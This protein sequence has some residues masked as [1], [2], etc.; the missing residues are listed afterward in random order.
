MRFA[1]TLSPWSAWKRSMNA[2]FSTW[3][4]TWWRRRFSSA[5]RSSGGCCD[6]LRG[7][8][9]SLTQLPVEADALVVL[10]RDATLLRL[11]VVG[12]DARNDGVAFER[13][14]RWALSNA[15]LCRERVDLLPSTRLCWGY[16]WVTRDALTD[17]SGAVRHDR[18]LQATTTRQRAGD[19]GHRRPVDPAR[20]LGSVAVSNVV[21]F[22]ARSLSQS[23][24]ERLPLGGCSAA[25]PGAAGAG[26]ALGNAPGAPKPATGFSGPCSGGLGSGFRGFKAPPRPGGGSATIA[27]GGTK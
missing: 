2:L 21:V 4:A 17:L 14:G 12:D 10:A 13:A 22:H 25:Q 15:A 1:L 18:R 7:V 6:L 5:P 3:R 16:S 8:G 24:V 20:H 9:Q 23:G 19:G 11:G 26:L 27:T